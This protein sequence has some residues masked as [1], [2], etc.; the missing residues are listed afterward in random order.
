MLGYNQNYMISANSSVPRTPH[1]YQSSPILKSKIKILKP[2]RKTQQNALEKILF[3][4]FQLFLHWQP[5]S[6]MTEKL[7][8]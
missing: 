1:Q 3:S 5:L 8:V 6:N 7:S 4:S 2:K